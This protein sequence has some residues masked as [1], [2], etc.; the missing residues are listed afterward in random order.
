MIS[1][2][3]VSYFV[4]AL[5]SIDKGMINKSILPVLNQK[6]ISWYTSPEYWPV[7]ITVMQVWKTLGFNSIIYLA[8]IIGIPADYYEAATLDGAN[9]WQQ[10]R[11]ITLPLLVPTVITL[12]LLHMG[13]I[14]YA[15]FS[16]FYQVPMNS[17]ALFNTTNVIDTYVYRALIQIG[18]I[19]MS[20][21]AGFYQSLVG[22]VLVIISNMIVKKLSPDNAL[23]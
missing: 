2:I 11:F 18:D 6:P 8:T 19:G 21:A 5:L 9:K 16:L 13:R 12:F 4:Y 23:F 22:F 1:W 3:I 15:D 7:I 20:A 10:I 14:F 17:G